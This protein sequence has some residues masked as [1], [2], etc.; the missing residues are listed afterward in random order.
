MK[1]AAIFIKYF[2]NIS[3][4]SSSSFQYGYDVGYARMCIGHKVVQSNWI[5]SSDPPGDL[6][7]FL[8]HT[9]PLG[10]LFGQLFHLDSQGDLFG[11]FCKQRSL[12]SPA[13]ISQII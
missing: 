7:G 1:Y 5:P 10:Y 4:T 13:Y 8:V 12:G 9:D 3:Q 6:S 11:F 2:F